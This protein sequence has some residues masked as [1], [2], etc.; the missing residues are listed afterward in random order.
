M[1][2]FSW[3]HIYSLASAVLP[4]CACAYTAVFAGI[5][6]ERTKKRKRKQNET[7]EAVSKHQQAVVNAADLGRGMILLF[8]KV[9]MISHL[10]P[11]GL[12]EATDVRMFFE[13][14]SH[15]LFPRTKLYAK[16]IKHH[17]TEMYHA[18]V[19]R[20]SRRLKSAVVWAGGAIL[21][22]NFDL[23]TSKTSKEKYIGDLQYMLKQLAFMFFF[24]V[25]LDKMIGVVYW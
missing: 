23:W 14:C 1:T 7:K 16:M 4:L 2:Y 22:A 20:F 8:I 21:H 13:V 17:I 25:G 12:A 11:F 10:L 6:S 19:S 3:I 18:T 9:F 5:V 15:G 24:R